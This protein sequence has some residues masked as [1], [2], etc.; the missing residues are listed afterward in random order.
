VAVWHAA[1]RL[2]V[3]HHDGNPIEI[4]AVVVWKVVETAEA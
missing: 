4:A 3:N 2:K 1:A